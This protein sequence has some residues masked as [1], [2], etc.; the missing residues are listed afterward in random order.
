MSLAKPKPRRCHLPLERIVFEQE[1]QLRNATFDEAY[2]SQ[3]VD[4]LDNGD[5]L[6]PLD[7]VEV[8]RGRRLDPLWLCIDGH[9]RSEAYRRKGVSSVECLVYAGSREDAQL[10]ALSSNSR[11]PLARTPEDCRRAFDRL[12]GNALLLDRVIQASRGKGGTERGIAQ[13]CGI[14]PSIIGKYLHAS[15]LQSDRLTGKLIPLGTESPER[16]ARQE[17]S[18]FTHHVCS[19]LS[20]REV[21][22][23]FASG[24][25]VRGGL[26]FFGPR[27]AFR[28]RFRFA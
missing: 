12:I 4:A 6:P 14:S 23:C 22:M 28:Y 13:T 27:V 7:V 18:L 8:Q 16:V 15:G 10:W 19:L 11:Q 17:P 9:N 24:K 21:A 3:L 2:V 1:F 26:G 25:R 5:I 20:S